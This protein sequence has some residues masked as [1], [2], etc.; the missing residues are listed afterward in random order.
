MMDIKQLQIIEKKL[1]DT[2]PYGEGKLRED[3]LFSDMSDLITALKTEY[4]SSKAMSK[5]TVF[6]RDR[7][8]TYIYSGQDTTVVYWSNLDEGI[9]PVCE[10]YLDASY[11]SDCEFNW[12]HPSADDV[13]EHF[14]NR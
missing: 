8:V 12:M 6:V 10:D 7:V 3:E 9:C 5:V 2:V 4:R 11:C 13:I 1:S 14:K